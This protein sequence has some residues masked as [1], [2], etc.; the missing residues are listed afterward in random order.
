MNAQ[1]ESSSQKAKRI[2]MALGV[3]VVLGFF[4]YAISLFG[5]RVLRDWHSI[6]PAYAGIGI[7]W[8]C[9]GPAMLVAGL[10]MLGTLGR[11]R[12]PFLITGYAAAAAGIVLI[13][14]VLTFV[15]PCS[16]PS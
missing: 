16:G 12:I 9:T 7:L 6:G 3:S 8:L 11:H 5:Y 14:G 2:S 4:G 10:W 13:V 15:V 1:T